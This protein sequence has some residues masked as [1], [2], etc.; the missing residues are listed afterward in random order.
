MERLNQTLLSLKSTQFLL[1]EDQNKVNATENDI[2]HL[3]QE[4]VDIMV[5]KVLTEGKEAQ[6]RI[7]ATLEEHRRE[8]SK[9]KQDVDDKISLLESSMGFCRKI[10]Q[11]GRDGEI[12]FLQETMQKRLEYLQSS[13]QCDKKPINDWTLPSIQFSKLT[14]K[15]TPLGLFQFESSSFGIP[16]LG[17]VA[18]VSQLYSTEITI[19]KDET[20]PTSEKANKMDIDTQNR[21][22]KS[23]TSVKDGSK[24][25]ATVSNDSTQC[26]PREEMS[27]SAIA[28]SISRKISLQ[29]VRTIDCLA[30]QDSNIPKLSSV[31]WIDSN[32]FAVVDETNQKLKTYNIDGSCINDFS[33]KNILT[34]ACKNEY[35][36]CGHKYSKITTV[37]NGKCIHSNNTL[38]RDFCP[39]VLLNENVLAIGQEH[40]YTIPCPGTTM[41]PKCVPIIN[42]QGFQMNLRPRFPQSFKD[43]QIVVSD[44]NSD[45]VYLINEN[46]KVSS[47]Y[48]RQDKGDWIPGGLTCD[49]MNN[50]YIAHHRRHQLTVIN[51]DM[52]YVDTLKLSS[53]T[54]PRC[55]A[56]SKAN[57]L[58]VACDKTVVLFDILYE[59]KV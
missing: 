9:Q 1:T 59:T 20:I 40:I 13:V 17:S 38:P 21:K 12:I 42:K 10:I 57:K 45:T 55:L 48:R 51:S 58:L 36:Y 25:K 26:Q 37:V 3:I 22:E 4:T 16:G 56:C 32:T 34:V 33:V 5:G 19:R 15:H 49:N 7:K 44:W 27:K 8:T 6:N 35:M 2:C 52:K 31:S 24:S 23:Q 28:P 47:A 14:D 41:T 46:G 50:I 54:N 39:P 18:D 43:S 30:N 29:Y 11:D 53:N